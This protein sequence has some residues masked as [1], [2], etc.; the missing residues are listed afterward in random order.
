MAD[1]DEEDADEIAE[2]GVREIEQQ[3]NLYATSP[4]KLEQKV[5]IFRTIKDPVTRAMCLQEERHRSEINKHTQPILKA[6]DEEMEA[7]K[8]REEACK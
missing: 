7:R 5:H 3:H 8:A 6:A 4:D 1:F 2:Q